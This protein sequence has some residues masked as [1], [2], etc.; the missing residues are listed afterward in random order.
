MS[1]RI[2]TP[3]AKPGQIIARWGRPGPREYPEVVY[4]WGGDGA[5]KS[6]ARI[7]SNALEG[8]MEHRENGLLK[9]LEARGYDLTT[10][11]FSIQ[12]ATPET[13]A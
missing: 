1:K 8:P 5:A 6:D 13:E 7:L 10:L 2:H 4:A 12:K 3:R 11:K 9:E